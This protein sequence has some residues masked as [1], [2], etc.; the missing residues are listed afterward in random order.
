ML[1]PTTDKKIRVERAK[2]SNQP[3]IKRKN[4]MTRYTTP[5]IVT[6]DR[7]RSISQSRIRSS[8]T[9]IPNKNNPSAKN[10]DEDED[11]EESLNERHVHEDIRP[12]KKN[13][14]KHWD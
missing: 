13:R 11:D 9:E 4:K 12:K 14:R 5:A 10:E 1:L 8:R 3:N 7:T 6:P 2:H